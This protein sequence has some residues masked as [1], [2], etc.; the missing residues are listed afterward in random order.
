MRTCGNCAH[1]QMF[2]LRGDNS[3]VAELNACTMGHWRGPHSA[4]SLLNHPLRYKSMAAACPD[5]EPRP[6]V[7]VAPERSA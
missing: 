5:F 2:I 4:A 6:A 7:E 3:F 1:C